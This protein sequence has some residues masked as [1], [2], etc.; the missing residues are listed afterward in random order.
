MAEPDA[1]HLLLYDYVEGMLE[2][3]VPYREEHLARIATG[4]PYV[5]AGLVPAWHVERWYV[6]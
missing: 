3:R 1:H 4:D 2:R 5:R 6:M